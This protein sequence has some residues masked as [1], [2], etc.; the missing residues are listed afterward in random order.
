MIFRQQMQDVDYTIY[1]TD[2]TYYTEEIEGY[3]EWE[4]YIEARSWGVKSVDVYVTEFDFEI[5]LEE[6]DPDTFMPDKKIKL[7][8][9]NMEDLGWSMETEG[10]DLIKLGELITIQ[11][12]VV[13][14]K[15]K[16]ITIQF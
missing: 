15:S 9:Q 12:V 11:D 10:T 16:L 6:S 2:T 1:G 3:I 7:S 14:M 8:S 4:I 13:D 5:N